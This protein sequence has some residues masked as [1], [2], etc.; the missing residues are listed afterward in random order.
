MKRKGHPMSEDMRQQMTR[1]NQLVQEYR[2]IDAQ[3]D[4]LL[5]N[6]L[7]TEDRTQYRAL[8]RQRDDL[9]SQIRTMEQSL[10]AE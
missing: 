7:A 5:S 4:D 3:I 1:Y 6:A 9:F 8:A 10:F 2:T